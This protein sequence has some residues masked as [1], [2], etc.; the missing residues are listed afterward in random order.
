M[1]PAIKLGDRLSK[2][3]KK[4]LTRLGFNDRSLKVIFI[5]GIIFFS[6]C[7]MLARIEVFNSLNSS[8][9]A[10]L[11]SVESLKT[12]SQKMADPIQGSLQWLSLKILPNH[13]IFALRSPTA[14][15]ISLSLACCAISLYLKFRNRYL[16]YVFALLAATS[17]WVLLLS[18]QGYI[19][20][21]DT[22]FLAS[23]IICSCFIVSSSALSDKQKI[24]SAFLGSFATG[25]MAL[26]PFGF[27]ILPMVIII[28]TRSPKLKTYLKSLSKK[29]KIALSVPIVLI[30]V[31]TIGLAILK[32]DNLRVISGLDLLQRPLQIPKYLLYNIRSIF[33]MQQTQGLSTG[34][35][36][37]DFLLVGAI[38]LTIYEIFKKRIGRKELII[39]LGTALLISAIYGSAMSIIFAIPFTVAIISLALANMIRIIDAAFPINPYP[40]N[41][42]R[43]GMFILICLMMV[44]NVYTFVTATTR[45]N[46]PAK[47]NDIII[48]RHQ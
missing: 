35:L 34:T 25:L 10:R 5:G 14:I 37:P 16:P 6:L 43:S 27:L 47:I 11:N 26:Q 42:A 13:Q 1:N 33:G 30:P 36:R 17:P 19:P 20:G 15:L 23:I 38:L 7:L 41:I 3:T 46:T 22:F 21:I 4:V 24:T 12:L 44:L 28:C 29:Q 40:R 32:P 8:E 45:A 31:L 18:H 48:S 39:G 9:L 2:N